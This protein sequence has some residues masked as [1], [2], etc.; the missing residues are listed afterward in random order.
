MVPDTAVLMSVLPTYFTMV[1]NWITGTESV[2]Y[3]SSYATPEQ[4]I[5]HDNDGQSIV[6]STHGS[7]AVRYPKR[8]GGNSGLSWIDTQADAFLRFVNT[9]GVVVLSNNTNN[10]TAKLAG[11]AFSAVH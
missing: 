5:V 1:N 9:N 2:Q 7:T 11:I 3:V 8:D 6:G 4:Y 10:L